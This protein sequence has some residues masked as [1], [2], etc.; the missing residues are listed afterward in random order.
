MWGIIAKPLSSGGGLYVGAGTRG[1]DP[2]V[3]LVSSGSRVEAGFWR[4][5]DDGPETT[6]RFREPCQPAGPSLFG[7]GRKRFARMIS[8]SKRPESLAGLAEFLAGLRWS[9][10]CGGLSY[11][12]L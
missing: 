5:L 10:S 9:D 1:Q 8:A 2:E 4:T 12:V 6:W 3:R 11:I 7:A